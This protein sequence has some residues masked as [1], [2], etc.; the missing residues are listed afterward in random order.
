MYLISDV[1]EQVKK[2]LQ[3]KGNYLLATKFDGSGDWWEY[4]MLD[5]EEWGINIFDDYE[6]GDAQEPNTWKMSAYVCDEDGLSTDD[7]ITL[8]I[9]SFPALV[10]KT[11]LKLKELTCTR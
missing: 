3:A 8:D 1:R 5:G 11:R 9:E 7:W 10:L 6:F 2:Q 4:F